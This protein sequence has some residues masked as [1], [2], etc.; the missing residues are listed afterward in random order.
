[1]I[2]SEEK[3][4]RTFFTEIWV[5]GS[6]DSLFFSSAQLLI[7]YSAA[8]RMR[9]EDKRTNALQADSKARY[10]KLC[11]VIE[12]DGATCDICF[13]CRHNM[14]TRHSRPDNCWWILRMNFLTSPQD[15]IDPLYFPPNW[16]SLFF[17]VCV[18]F[19]SRYFYRNRR[20]I[21]SGI[22]NLFNKISHARLAFRSK[23][24]LL[25]LF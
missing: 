8:E 22:D 12:N 7:H 25:S 16:R 3:K 17:F 4:M 14:C 15:F 23:Q 24:N 1:M 6:M 18:C 19:F 20:W 11:V 5:N 9:G 21:I 2:V 13:I 10:W